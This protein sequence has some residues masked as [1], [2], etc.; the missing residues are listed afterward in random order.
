[1]PEPTKVG[2]RADTDQAMAFLRDSRPS[3]SSSPEGR[4]YANLADAVAQ[5][6]GCEFAGTPDVGRVL[7]SASR[8]MK[9]VSNAAR[10]AGLDSDGLLAVMA[11]AGEQLERQASNA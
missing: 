6:I 3:L 1:M 4:L 9:S 7:V 5:L 10:A 11:L 2:L 8:V